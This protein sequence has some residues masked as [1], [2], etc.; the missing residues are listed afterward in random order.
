VLRRKGASEVGRRAVA[1]TAARSELEFLKAALRA[2]Q[3]RG[4][5]S[6]ARAPRRRTRARRAEGRGRTTV[7]ADFRFHWL[8][9]TAILLMARAEMKAE[10]IAENVGIGR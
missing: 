9:H 1:R 6:A 4:Q 3:S 10:C 7:V 8:R 2:V 5:R